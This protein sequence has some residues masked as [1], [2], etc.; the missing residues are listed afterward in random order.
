M[1][2]KFCD[3]NIVLSYKIIELLYIAT[4]REIKLFIS[5]PQRLVKY[6]YL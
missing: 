6:Q 4:E 2:E 5:E 1:V 3:N